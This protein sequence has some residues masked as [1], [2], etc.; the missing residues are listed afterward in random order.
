MAGE[1]ENKK[2]RGIWKWELW[3]LTLVIGQA[4]LS[5]SIN[6]LGLS[7]EDNSVKRTDNFVIV[8][9]FNSV[10]FP[11]VLS[12]RCVSQYFLTTMPVGFNVNLTFGLT[13]QVGGIKIVTV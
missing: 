12:Y 9:V 1:V 3:L 7:D 4:A 2:I 5:S 10:T 13:P 8:N 11:R 6:C